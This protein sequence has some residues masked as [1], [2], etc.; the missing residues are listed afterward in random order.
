MKTQ[1]KSVEFALKHLEDTGEFTGYAS[2]FEVLDGQ[3]DVV[4]KGAFLRSLHNRK[5]GKGV[6]L[7]WQHDSA[8]PIGVINQIYEDSH[9]LFMQ[10]R[11]VLDVLKGREAYSLLKHQITTGL[12][13]GYTIVDS[14]YDEFSGVRRLKEVDLWEV[15]LVTFPANDEARVL[16]VKVADFAVQVF[17]ANCERALGFLRAAS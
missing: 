11:L 10:A 17:L 16:D 9:G 12:S 1:Y 6:K 3:G 2:V 15:S 8:Q 4:E 13:I 7:L 5:A 14:D